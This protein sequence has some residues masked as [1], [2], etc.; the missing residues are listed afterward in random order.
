M[1]A[2]RITPKLKELIKEKFI[3][4]RNLGIDTCILLSDSYITNYPT[5]LKSFTCS[6]KLIISP[7][8]ICKYRISTKDGEYWE[9]SFNNTKITNLLKRI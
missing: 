1:S 7:D 4:N 5:R 2:F 6:V 3:F 8:K 9:H